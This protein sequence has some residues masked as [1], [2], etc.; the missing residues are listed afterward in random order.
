MKSKSLQVGLKQLAE[1]GTLQLFQRLN[2]SDYIIGVVGTLQ[3]E[4]VVARLRAEYKVEGRAEP[5]TFNAARWIEAD[6]P[7]KM[8]QFKSQN[9]HNLALDAENH[10]TYLAESDWDID[11]TQKD[12]PDIR[13]LKYVEHS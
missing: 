13:F 12:W 2:T 5:T 1:E 4:V 8:E 3:F 7:K 9:T 6:D 11:R 10:L